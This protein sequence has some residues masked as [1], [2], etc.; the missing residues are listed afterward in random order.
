[1]KFQT[2]LK[3]TGSLIDMT[4]LVDVIFLL[5][6]FF[7][8][9]S[10]TLPLKS[11]H[12]DKPNISLNDTPLTTQLVLVIDNEEVIYLGSSKDIVDLESLQNKLHDEIELYKKSHSN[13]T[14]TITLNI[15]KSIPYDTF[16]QVLNKVYST[17]ATIRLA[18]NDETP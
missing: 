10:D 16:L 17:G 12:L 1:M 2:R 13:I 4:P 8:I 7:I 14:P 6:V 5:L 15:D 11:I 18:Y 3:H 9:T